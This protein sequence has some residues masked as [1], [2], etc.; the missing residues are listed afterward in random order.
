MLVPASPCL[1]LNFAGLTACHMRLAVLQAEHTMG[2]Q[3][4]IGGDK[5][6]NAM[7]MASQNGLNLTRLQGFSVVFSCKQQRGFEGL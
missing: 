2:L 6:G 4:C 7:I 1:Q 5:D 3:G